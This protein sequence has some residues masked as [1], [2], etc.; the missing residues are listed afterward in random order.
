MSK[1]EDVSIWLRCAVDAA[2]ALHVLLLP[3]LLAL[4]THFLLSLL[5]PY[6]PLPL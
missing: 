5:H 4:P 6:H 2:S 3:P 1:V